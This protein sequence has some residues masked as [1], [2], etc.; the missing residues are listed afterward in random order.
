MEIGDQYERLSLDFQ[1]K[2]N[3]DDDNNNDNN[4]DNKA[5]K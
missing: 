4:N 1:M 2:A 5:F 3:R